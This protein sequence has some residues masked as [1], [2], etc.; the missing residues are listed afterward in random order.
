M[1]DS[2]LTMIVNDKVEFDHMDGK[3]YA[4][5]VVEVLRGK[6]VVIE[7]TKEGQRLFYSTRPPT[8]RKLNDDTDNHRR[9][10]TD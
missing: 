5:T 3:I 9:S 1:M 10:N 8:V 2:R 7:F 4:G 6:G